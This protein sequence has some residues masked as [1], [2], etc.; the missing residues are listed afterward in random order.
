MF[1]RIRKLRCDLKGTFLQFLPK[2]IFKENLI[3]FLF[4]FSWG[5]QEFLSCHIPTLFKSLWIFY[6]CNIFVYHILC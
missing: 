6:L 2:I 4:L 1:N 3:N 5:A